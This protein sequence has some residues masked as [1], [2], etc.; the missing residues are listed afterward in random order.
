M[1][2]YSGH[3]EESAP[4]TQKVVLMLFKEALSL[5]G[6]TKTRRNYDGGQLEG[7]QRDIKINASGGVGSQQASSL[8]M[9][10]NRNPGHD[11]RKTRAAKV[12]T[13]AEFTDAKKTS[14][15]EQG[16]RQ[17]EIRGRSKDDSGKAAREGNIGQLYGV[18]KKLVGNY[19]KPE[20]LVKDKEGKR[21]TEIREQGADDLAHLSYTR[22]QMWMK[23]TSVAAAS[24]V[25]GVDIHSGK[26]KIL[27]HNTENTNSITLD[28]EALGIFIFLGSII[29]KQGGSDADINVRI[30]KARVAFLQ[31]RNI[32]N[33]KQIQSNIKVQAVLVSFQNKALD[34]LA[35]SA[36]RILEIT[37]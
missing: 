36:D 17:A 18:T 22:K 25:V 7:D 3:V 5:T 23:T 2:L 24:T 9:D 27:E 19:G 12:K 14:E 13:Q 28:G 8:G 4:H 35:A 11:T 10:L 30:G 6:S 20:K 37:K 32:W 1:V 16:S 21:I 26:S 15:V 33:S 34:E 29:G 31:L